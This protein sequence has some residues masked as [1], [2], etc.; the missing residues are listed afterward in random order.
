MKIQSTGEIRVQS[1]H[2]CVLFDPGDGEIRHVH[3]VMTIEGAAVPSEKAIE[4]RARELAKE[5][6]LDSRRLG[7]LHVDAAEIEPGH[8]YRVD[9][10][11]RRLVK[12]RGTAKGP[13]VAV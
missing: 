7:A 1:V 13:R 12:R 10:K 4:A 2:C 6:G 8:S 5:S 11:K 9:A 3:H